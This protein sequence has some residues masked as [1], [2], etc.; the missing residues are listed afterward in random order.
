MEQVWNFDYLL[1]LGKPQSLFYNVDFTT[2]FTIGAWE[3][4]LVESAG[5]INASL[6]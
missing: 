3:A 1:S 2:H 4:T 5:D 6:Y